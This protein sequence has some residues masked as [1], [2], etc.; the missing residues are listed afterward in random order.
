MIYKEARECVDKINANLTNIRQLLLTLYERQ[1][2]DALGYRNW[3]ECIKKELTK[4]TLL[5]KR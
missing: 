2:W 5:K 1:G 4:G 3:Q